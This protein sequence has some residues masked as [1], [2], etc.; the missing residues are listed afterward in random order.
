MA[1]LSRCPAS[2]W[3][4][5]AVFWRGETALTRFAVA[6]SLALAATV[7]CLPASASAQAEAQNVV[8]ARGVNGMFGDRLVPDAPVIVEGIDD[9]SA[10]S[11]GDGYALALKGDGTVW[12]WGSNGSGILG[13]GTRTIRIRPVRLT[14]LWDVTAIAAGENFGVALRKDGTVWAWGIPGSR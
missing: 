4:G 14:N 13:E 9:V 10:I 8:W 7:L 3:L 5:A 1:D 2:P 6:L 11:G 12:A